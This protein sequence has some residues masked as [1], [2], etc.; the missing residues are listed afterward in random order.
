MKLSEIKGERTIEVVAELIEPIAVISQNQNARELFKR[1]KVPAG[2]TA[3][4]FFLQRVRATV[5][6][7]L[8]E[9]KDEII[10]VLAT[11]KGVSRREY[12][13]SMT[14]MS[15][16]IDVMELLGDQ[17]F[18]SFFSSASST[19][20]KESFGSQLENTEEAAQ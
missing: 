12:A 19:A 1:R 11:I 2:M 16:T 14:L 6:S 7:L 8:T 3:N 5:P 15:L 10:T 9:C 20:E 4:E 13:E 18:L 17:E